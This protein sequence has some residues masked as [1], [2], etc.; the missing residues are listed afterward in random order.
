MRTLRKIALAAA[1]AA[2]S[3][4]GTAATAS[5]ATSR[6]AAPAT[7]CDWQAPLGTWHYPSSSTIYWLS[8][9]YCDRYARGAVWAE[10][11]TPTGDYSWWKMWIYNATNGSS[12]I[13]WDKGANG[14]VYTAPLDDAGTVSRV[15]VQPYDVGGTIA[16]G[17]KQC[18]TPDF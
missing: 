3:L 17:M 10:P 15:C 1:V 8:F 11:P 5:A 7:S 18:T 12:N 14:N 13:A 9:D 4:G 6:P 16:I 2:T